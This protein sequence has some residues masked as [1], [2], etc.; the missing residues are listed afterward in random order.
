MKGIITSGIIT[1][2]DNKIIKIKGKK[3]NYPDQK[4]IIYY[5]ILLLYK[6]NIFRKIF[7]LSYKK[8]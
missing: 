2:I 4:N 5:V 8:K 1:N 3:I 6:K 7:K